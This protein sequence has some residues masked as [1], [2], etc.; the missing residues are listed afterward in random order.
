MTTTTTTASAPVATTTGSNK[1]MT[2]ERELRQRERNQ[3]HYWLLVS[4]ALESKLPAKI[5]LEPRLHVCF[6]LY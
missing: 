4:P 2:S 5:S 6:L 1:A 3:L